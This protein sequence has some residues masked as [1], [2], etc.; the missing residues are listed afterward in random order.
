MTFDLDIMARTGMGEARGEG[1][2]GMQAVMWTGV[3]RFTAKRWYSGL[4]IAGTLLKAMQYDCWMQQDPNY[5]YIINLTDS[6]GLFVQALQYAADIL[7][8]NI[9]DPTFGATHYYADSLL[10]PPP[11]VKGA[12][13]TVK[14]GKQ[15]F[16]KNVA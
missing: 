8:G 7:K 3:N 2:E 9:A 14:I 4:T 1:P 12:T 15:S 6:I 16:Y 5:A 11:W 10:H 13:L